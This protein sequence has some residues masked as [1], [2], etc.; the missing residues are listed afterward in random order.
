MLV[1]LMQLYAK[2]GRFA[3][4]E[5]LLQQATVQFRGTGDEVKIVLA[6]ADL[7]LEKGDVDEAL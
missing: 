7:L 5:K 3:E 2:A 1:T 6:R 4:S